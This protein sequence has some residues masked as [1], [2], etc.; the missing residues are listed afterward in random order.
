[1]KNIIRTLAAVILL[2]TSI[3][4]TALPATPPLEITEETPIAYAAKKNFFV[5]EDAS[6]QMRIDDLLNQTTGFRSTAEL[7][8]INSYSNY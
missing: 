7:P 1:M 6:A 4:A 8:T 2:G 5:F 3:A